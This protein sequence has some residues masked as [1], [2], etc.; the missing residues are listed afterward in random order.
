MAVGRATQ[1]VLSSKYPFSYCKPEIRPVGEFCKASACHL[2]NYSY[3]KVTIV[4]HNTGTKLLRSTCV[5]ADDGSMVS[6]HYCDGERPG[7]ETL[8]C[9]TQKCLAR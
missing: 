3:F 5:R 2:L 4:F 6:D 9:N 1:G 7:D 8:E